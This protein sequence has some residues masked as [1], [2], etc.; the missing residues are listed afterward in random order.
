MP[1]RHRPALES[2]PKA[3]AT[4][5]P[6]PACRPGHGKQGAGVQT[7]TVRAKF[8]LGCTLRAPSAELDQA[9]ADVLHVLAPDAPHDVVETVLKEYAQLW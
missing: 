3:K 9:L 8:Y 4:D 5:T 7:Q 6:A 1:R 2:A